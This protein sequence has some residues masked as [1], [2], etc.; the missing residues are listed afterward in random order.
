MSQKQPVEC[1]G[2][3][4]ST[5]FCPMCGRELSDAGPLVGLLQ[6]VSRFASQFSRQLEDFPSAPL[7]IENEYDRAG[8]TKQLRS[9]QAAAEKWEAWRAALSEVVNPQEDE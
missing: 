8:H 5:P 7:N 3:M 6:H 4:H 9:H 2:I 1:C